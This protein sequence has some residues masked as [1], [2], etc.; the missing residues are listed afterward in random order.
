M[1]GILSLEHFSWRYSC[2]KPPEAY[3]ELILQLIQG[4]LEVKKAQ[5]I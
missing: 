3:E 4:Y 5:Q 1:N 2:Q